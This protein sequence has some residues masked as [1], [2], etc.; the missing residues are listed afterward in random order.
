MSAAGVA[1]DPNPD[2]SEPGLGVD[3]DMDT[4]Q[5]LPVGAG[6]GAGPG[7]VTGPQVGVG[8]AA[9]SA[10]A[11]VVVG[12][13]GKPEAVDGGKAPLEAL[14]AAAPTV[15]IPKLTF[16]QIFVLFLNFGIR[17]FG[18]YVRGARWGGPGG[19]ACVPFS[20]SA[21]ATTLP[22]LGLSTFPAC[23]TQPSSRA[24]FPKAC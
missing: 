1:P 11:V 21:T 5:H 24:P 17:A 14:V 23:P 19:V 7:Q 12:P 6:G 18:G 20:L 9:G 4:V 10:G 16:W 2:T 22:W 15:G 8:A 13:E 3:V